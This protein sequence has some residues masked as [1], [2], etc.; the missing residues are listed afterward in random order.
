MSSVPTPFADVEAVF[1][2]LDDTLCGYWDAAKAGLKHTLDTIEIPGF[3]AEEFHEAWVEEFR[4]FA[5]DIKTSHW[6]EIYLTQGGVTRMELMRMALQRLGI[7]NP[8]LAFELGRVY[9]E[10]RAKRLCLFDDAQDVLRWVGQRFFTGVITNGPADIQRQELRDLGIE[11]AFDVVLIEGEMG[12]GKPVP[13]VM[14]RAEKAAGCEGRK[15]LMVGNSYR[16]D[17]LPAMEAGWS[18]AWIRRPSDVPPTS[19][20]NEPEALPEGG[21]EPDAT[22]TNL[23]QLRELLTN[24]PGRALRGPNVAER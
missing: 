1:F 10:E 2:D 24:S 3:T 7:D 5:N 23:E 6:Y 4:Q 18:T 22:I 12:E 21:V 11:D 17:I 13:R 20:R 9:G 8:E 15:I 14:R 16:H 19:S